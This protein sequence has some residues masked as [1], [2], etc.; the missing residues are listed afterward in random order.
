M[1][2]PNPRKSKVNAYK[3]TYKPN[4]IF[5][6]LIQGETELLSFQRSCSSHTALEATCA[7]RTV[8]DVFFQLLEE[9]LEFWNRTV[10]PE[11]NF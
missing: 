6:A 5:A 9:S 8:T 7:V 11:V 3:F 4:E 10:T 1:S 2:Q